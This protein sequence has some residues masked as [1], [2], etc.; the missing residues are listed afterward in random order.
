[1]NTRFA[2]PILMGASLLA[3]APAM[4]QVPVADA[5]REQAETNTAVCMQRARTFK[6]GSVAP[7]KN[8]NGSVTLQ[9]DT[10]GIRSVTGQTVTGQAFSGT[11]IGGNDFALL[12]GVASSIQAIK[13]KNVGQA[14]AS[15]AAVATALS[16]NST[17]LSTQSGSIGTAAT[18]KG[19]FEQDAVA[20]LSNAQVWN[21]VIQAVG[22]ANQLRNQRIL[23]LS[24]A[25]SAIAKVM[26]YDPSKVIL[27]NP[28]QQQGN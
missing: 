1:M 20:R 12:L 19:A 24:A 25:D 27:T 3:P 13:T 18:I 23:D 26:T 28:Q 10:G 11:M 14:A 16:S 2:L 5:Q 4:A 7:T 15:L 21:Q 22:A 8:I 17:S 9:G 6:Q